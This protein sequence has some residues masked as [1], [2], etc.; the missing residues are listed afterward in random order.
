MYF[1]I[2]T[3][4]YV[5]YKNSLEFKTILNMLACYVSMVLEGRVTWDWGTDIKTINRK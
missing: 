5:L 2:Y 1:K 4:H 3:K